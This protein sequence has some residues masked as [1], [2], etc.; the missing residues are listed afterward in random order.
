MV[1][2]QMGALDVGCVVGAAGSGSWDTQTLRVSLHDLAT[3]VQYHFLATQHT[4]VGD[5][6][7]PV[8]S[9]PLRTRWLL[10]GR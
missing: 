2:G 8:A 7:L 4:G 5:C 10:A 9:L 3:F 6:F 1:E